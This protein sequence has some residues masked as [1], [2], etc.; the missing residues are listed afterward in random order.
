MEVMTLNVEIPKQIMYA[1][2]Q[3]E[4]EFINKMKLF[5]AVEYY[6]EHKLSLGKAAELAG[7]KKSEFMFYLGSIG[8]SVINYSP[9]ELDKE[10]ERFDEI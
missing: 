2:N 4:N 9:D 3:D 6:R 1:L 7:K 8:E 10:L 5:T